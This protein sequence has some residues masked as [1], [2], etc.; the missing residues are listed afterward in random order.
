MV[1]RPRLGFI[2]LGLMGAPMVRRLLRQGW[3]VTVWNREPDR[4]PEVEPAGARVAPDPA[5]VRR[6]SDVVLL[7]VLDGDAVEAC[8]FGPGGLAHAGEGAGLL[9]DTSTIDPARTRALAARLHDQAGVE[10]VDAPLSGGPGPAEEGKLTVMMGGEAGPVEAARAVL[11][12]LSANLT[13]AGPL[14]AGQVAKVV[15]QAIVGTSYLLMAE[16]LALAEATDMDVRSLPACLAGGMADSTVLQ[17]IFPQMQ[18]RDYDQP[19]GYVRQLDKDLQAV[20]AFIG[21]RGLDLPVVTQAIERYHAYAAAGH[22]M[23]DSASVARLY[24]AA[25]HGT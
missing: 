1:D 12:D 13:H 17:R 19:K 3:Q 8:C 21:A 11:G 9:I 7:C 16:A 23:E 24:E 25:R 2:G 10:W 22:G 4:Y 18:A 6:D 14:G 15:N 5:A 20:A